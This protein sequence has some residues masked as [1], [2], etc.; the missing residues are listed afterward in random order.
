MATWERGRSSEAIE[1]RHIASLLQ[2]ATKYSVPN[3]MEDCNGDLL[4]A[5]RFLGGSFGSRAR[6]VGLLLCSILLLACQLL[7]LSFQP[8]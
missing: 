3:R 4:L 6:G 7:K 5:R 1:Q 2:I 8:L